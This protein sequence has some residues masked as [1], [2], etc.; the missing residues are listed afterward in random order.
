MKEWPRLVYL[1]IYLFSSWPPT[2]P[3]VIYKTDKKPEEPCSITSSLS[4]FPEEDANDLNVTS[5]PRIPPS[6]LTVVTVEG[7]PS[8]IILDWQKSDNETTGRADTASTLKLAAPFLL[9]GLSRH[10]REKRCC[11]FS[12]FLQSTKFSPP[13]KEKAGWRSLWW[14]P[15][16]HTRLWRTSNQRASTSPQ[17]RCC[18]SHTYTPFMFKHCVQSFQVNVKSQISEIMLVLPSLLLSWLFWIVCMYNCHIHTQVKC[19]NNCLFYW[20]SAMNSQ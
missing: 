7:C 12:A 10:K 18:Y 3:H 5:P 16:R 19:D 9:S 20:I 13:P 1:C 8:F 11:S 6:N 17:G 4:Y 14:P 15:I 2:A